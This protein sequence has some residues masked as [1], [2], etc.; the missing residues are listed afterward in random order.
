MKKHF[1]I[2]LNILLT[3]TIG[4]SQSFPYP[5]RNVNTYSIVAYDKKNGVLHVVD[6]KHGEGL[7]IEV[8]NNLQL[9][10]YALGA[11]TT[12]KYPCRY[13]QM[14]IVQPRAYHPDGSI[15]HWRI[16]SL[17]FLDVEQ[18]IISEAE[19]TRN[20]KAILHAG[21]HCLFCPAKKIPSPISVSKSKFFSSSVR[22]NAFCTTSMVA[23]DCFIKS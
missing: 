12:L 17:H 3:G 18:S 5:L 6:Y 2:I 4:L 10:Y 22:L 14:T 1:L 7:V 11:L 9:E 13:V 20:P 23:G 15:R 19:E 16:P 8:K 21:S